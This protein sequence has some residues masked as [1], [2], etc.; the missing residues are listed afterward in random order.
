[1]SLITAE[2]NSSSAERQISAKAGRS[3]GTQRIRWL[4]LINTSSRWR[5]VALVNPHQALEAYVSLEIITDRY[6]MCNDES[7]IQCVRNTLKAYRACAWELMMRFVC[8]AT[9][10]LLVKV[11]PI[12]LIT[13]TRLIFG[14]GRG[15]CICS[16]LLRL[17][18]TKQ[19]QHTCS[20]W[21]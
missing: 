15:G 13:V 3:G 9:Y 5:S 4:R 14:S 7:S 8:S 10:R 2:N 18:S 20:D 11:T 16:F 21:P 19:C 12:I 17:V 1:M 6:M